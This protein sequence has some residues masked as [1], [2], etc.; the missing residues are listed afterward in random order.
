MWPLLAKLQRSGTGLAQPRGS[1]RVKTPYHMDFHTKCHMLEVAFV[2]NHVLGAFS[3]HPTIYTVSCLKLCLALYDF[4]NVWYH[5]SLWA[6]VTITKKGK[7]QLMLLHHSVW[8][9]VVCC[10]SIYFK[11]TNTSICFCWAIK[12]FF[13]NAHFV[14]N[15]LCRRKEVMYVTLE[16][17]WHILLSAPP[18]H[19]S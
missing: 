1:E 5:I 9:G 18:F 10:D 16:E 14:E 12:S 17:Q 15:H 19:E 3:N 13:L 8:H 7:S 11:R 6:Q 4:I 2:W